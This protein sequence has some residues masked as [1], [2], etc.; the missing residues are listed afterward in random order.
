MATES[1]RVSSLCGRL[2]DGWAGDFDGDGDTDVVTANIG[3]RNWDTREQEGFGVAWY[4][5]QGGGNFITHNLTTNLEPPR[6]VVVTDLDGDGDRDVISS[7]GPLEWHR[8]N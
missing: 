2:W 1:Q 5:N 4:E 8:N 6:V 7:G 3:Q